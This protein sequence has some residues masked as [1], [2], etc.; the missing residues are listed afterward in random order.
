MCC[1]DLSGQRST[2][3][4]RVDLAER[5]GQQKACKPCQTVV[6]DVILVLHQL[7]RF[8]P[9]LANRSLNF[10][11]LVLVSQSRSRLGIILK[12]NTPLK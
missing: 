4:Q 9:K 11:L 12:V 3:I 8:I 1:P 5:R 7:S 2:D 6:E 10:I